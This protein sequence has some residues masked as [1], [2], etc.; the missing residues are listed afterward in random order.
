VAIVH[1]N[2]GGLSWKIDPKMRIRVFRDEFK[3]IMIYYLIP[4]SKHWEFTPDGQTLREVSGPPE[5]RIDYEG[6]EWLTKN[7]AIRYLTQV[8]DRT[9]DPTIKK[10]AEE[11]IA[12]LKRHR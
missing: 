8:R 9:S 12:V 2:V 5:W 4:T 7:N 11:S 6:E 10:N 1:I 3:G